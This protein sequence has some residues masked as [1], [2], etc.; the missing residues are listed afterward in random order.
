MLMLSDDIINIIYLNQGSTVTVHEIE[1][2][3]K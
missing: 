1:H 2:N 3:P